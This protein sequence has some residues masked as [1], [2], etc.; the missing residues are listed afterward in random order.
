MDERF[1]ALLLSKVHNTDR[2]NEGNIAQ[3]TQELEQ[4]ADPEAVDQAG[5]SAL[6][7]SAWYNQIECAETLLQFGAAP[8]QTEEGG[9]TALHTAAFLGRTEI[10]ELLLDGGAEVN[11]RS[12]EG[13]TPLNSLR[14]SWS[15]VEW[16]AG[17]LNV[18]V[19]RREVLAGRKKLEPI[20]IARGATSQNGAASKESSS[21]LQD[22]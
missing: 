4:G 2:E 3:L 9:H 20:L 18:T 13:K 16:I 11:V 8:N 14:E 1:K 15:T 5:Q 22:L 12:R 6:M 7:V 10:A 17:M 21:A 19:D